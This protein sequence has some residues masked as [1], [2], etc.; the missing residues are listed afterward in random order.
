MQR[1]MLLGMWWAFIVEPRDGL[2]QYV[3]NYTLL[4]PE[5][6]GLYTINGHS[7]PKT[8]SRDFPSD[9]VLGLGNE[10]FLRSKNCFSEAATLVCSFSSAS[11]IP[12]IGT[13]TIM[14][15]DGISSVPQNGKP[16]PMVLW[17]SSY[18]KVSIRR[19][20]H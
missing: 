17:A 5:T 7:F 18:P 14:F 13:A 8:L 12:P 9:I 11:P 19:R 2:P 3:R 6:V 4:L 20:G 15:P 1:A 10:A 16:E